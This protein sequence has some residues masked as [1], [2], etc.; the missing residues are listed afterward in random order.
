MATPNH[1]KPNVLLPGQVLVVRGRT[2][3]NVYHQWVDC[4]K[5]REEGTHRTIPRRIALDR[6]L[7][8]CDAC[9]LP[10]QTK[11]PVEVAA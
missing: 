4:H 5:L 11:L 1:R 7:I 6:G 9:R 3:T 8:L 10:H 2:Q